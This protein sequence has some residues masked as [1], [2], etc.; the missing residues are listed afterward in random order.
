M[1]NEQFAHKLDFIEY[2]I[3]DDVKSTSMG[4]VIWLHGLGANAQDFV[5]LIPELKLK[6]HIKFIFPNAP[7]RTITINN[8]ALMQAWYDIR[9][10]TKIDNAVD[11]DG[12]DHSV[13][14]VENLIDY[15]IKEEQKPIHIAVVG[16]SQGGVI[17]YMMALRSQH[18]F[19][20]I[21]ALSCY[22]PDVDFNLVSNMNKKTPILACHGKYDMIVPYD[23]GLE[24][25][26]K[27]RTHGFNISWKGYP[28]DHGV[29]LDEIKD[30]SLWFQDRFI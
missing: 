20:G 10:M 3:N 26:N 6:S 19:A 8:G 2:T 18:R 29:C 21:L 5:P 13:L 22:L 30:I 4:V 1:S 27:F 11:W 15:L 25:Y 12:I 16:F 17:A 23:T 24:S 9:D 14:Q 28:M 7:Q